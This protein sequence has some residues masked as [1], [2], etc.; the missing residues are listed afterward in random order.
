M[1]GHLLIESP[2]SWDEV[3]QAHIRGLF[4]DETYD[5]ILN[6]IAIG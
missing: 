4:D 1:G 2:N 3:E 6:R 5:E